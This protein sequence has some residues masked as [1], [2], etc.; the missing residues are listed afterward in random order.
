MLHSLSNFFWVGEKRI[1]PGC[2]TVLKCNFSNW[3]L[4]ETKFSDKNVIEK[5]QISKSSGPKPPPP[6]LPMP[7]ISYYSYYDYAM[8]LTTLSFQLQRYATATNCIIRQNISFKH[9]SQNTSF[10]AFAS[11]GHHCE[12]G[13]LHS[14]SCI[15]DSLREQIINRISLMPPSAQ[16]FK[17]IGCL[18]TLTY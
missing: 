7:M 3:K 9:C 15:L 18:S 6:H 4:R 14:I 17:C 13:V 1:V 2:P 10:S 16:T 11:G 12:V 8:S 5:Y